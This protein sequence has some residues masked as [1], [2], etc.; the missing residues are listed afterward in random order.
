MTGECDAKYIM[1]NIYEPIM[2]IF[3]VDD[4][5]NSLLIQLIQAPA[6]LMQYPLLETSPS[7]ATAVENK[8]FYL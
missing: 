7:V 8:C 1:P 6:I 5:C 3:R 4:W 2:V